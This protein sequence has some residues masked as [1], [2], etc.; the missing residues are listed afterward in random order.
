MKKILFQLVSFCA[1]ICLFV[2]C[3]TQRRAADA[4]IIC[5]T[6]LYDE[7]VDIIF[8]FAGAASNGVFAA[9]KERTNVFV[10]GAGVDQFDL[11][12][13]DGRNVVLTSVLKIMKVNVERALESIAIGTFAGG[14]KLMG[15]DTGSVGF[16]KTP[17]RHQL[18]SRT[19]RILEDISLLI[20]RGEIVPPGSLTQTSPTN[21][22][23]L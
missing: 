2:A 1:A 12:A 15:I 10:I 6:A 23:G 20:E 13:A 22:P 17:G 21:F 7:G 16:V 18:S 11:G 5:P 9:A 19:L 14:N 3:N 4:T 8:T